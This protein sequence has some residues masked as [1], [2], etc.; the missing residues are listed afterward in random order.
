MSVAPPPVRR[1]TGCGRISERQGGTVHDE[2]TT[3]WTVLYGS[4]EMRGEG[5]RDPAS[6]ANQSLGMAAFAL[7]ARAGHLAEARVNLER[8][9]ADGGVDGT[10]TLYRGYW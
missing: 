4:R 3:Q 2:A 8:A 10:R 7:C 6:S 5:A 9:K 1:A